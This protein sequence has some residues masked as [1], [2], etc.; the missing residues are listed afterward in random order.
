M[1]IDRRTLLAALPALAAAPVFAAPRRKAAAPPPLPQVPAVLPD[2]VTVDL[3]TELGTIRLALDAKN[4]PLTTR[5]FLT[6]ALQKRFDGAAFYRAMKLNWGEQP[7]G[8][9]Q[10]GTQMDPR[11]ILPPVAHEPTS[12]T[13]ILHKRGAIS[14]ARY[15]P[16]TATGDFSI[17]LSDQPSLDADPKATDPEVL[18]G[19]AAFGHVTAGMDVAE[20]IFAAPTSATKGEGVMRG[21]MLEPVVKILSVRM[22]P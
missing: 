6:Y 13:G 14:M 18:A 12:Q 15:A 20:K 9:I 16:G 11:R 21:Q 5:N 7:N 17:L 3:V 19:F 22:V 1:T 8:L 4:A 2:A 10:G